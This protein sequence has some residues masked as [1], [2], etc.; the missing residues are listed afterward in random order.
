MEKFLPSH[1]R[2]QRLTNGGVNSA[3][4][5]VS[6]G[7]PEFG[8]PAGLLIQW[9]AMVVAR[10]AQS[11]ECIPD[12]WNTIV[13]IGNL[14]RNFFGTHVCQDCSDFPG[15]QS[16]GAARRVNQRFFNEIDKPFPLM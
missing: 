8:E 6:D 3:F 5:P 4:V 15:G 9:S 13:D 1:T 7:N 10:L 2:R 12:F 16:T 11:R 14:L